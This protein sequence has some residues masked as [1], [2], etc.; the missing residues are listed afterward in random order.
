MFNCAAP[1]QTACYDIG[2]RSRRNTRPEKKTDPFL[3]FS[4]FRHTFAT[5]GATSVARRKKN[6]LLRSSNENK[7]PLL[8]P[9]LDM[10][11]N[12]VRRGVADSTRNTRRSPFEEDPVF[13]TALRGPYAYLQTSLEPPDPFE[14]A[15]KHHRRFRRSPFM[16]SSHGP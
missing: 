3:S 2:A 15:W 4:P 1:R 13:D 14:S 10:S 5:E 16:V 8:N 7:H 6:D 12:G 9:L 11:W